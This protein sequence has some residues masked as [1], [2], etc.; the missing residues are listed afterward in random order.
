MIDVD[1]KIQMF[2]VIA[3]ARRVFPFNVPVACHCE[4]RCDECL[5]KLLELLE[6]DLDN[7][8]DRLKR[9]EIPRSIDIQVLEGY[10]RDVAEV[11]IKDGYQLLS[12]GWV[13]GA[14]V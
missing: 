13:K 11:L 5:F 1:T 6:I 9:G 12:S 7:W 10:C 4:G 2:A 3:E 8:N 14:N